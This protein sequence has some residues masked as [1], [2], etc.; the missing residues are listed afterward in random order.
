M[1]TP[2]RPRRMGG[3]L[4]RRRRVSRTT[5]STHTESHVRDRLQLPVILLAAAL[6]SSC[7]ANLPQ[8]QSPAS[9]PS[10]PPAAITRGTSDQNSGLDTAV[11]EPHA[12]FEGSG[13]F[14]DSTFRREL[15]E[16]PRM[17]WALPDTF[18]ASER[19]ASLHVWSTGLRIHQARFA[20]EVST[21]EHERI[22]KDT[23][24]ACD[25][26]GP[27]AAYSLSDSDA[28][29]DRA[30]YTSH[31]P[32][33]G[34]SAGV[35]F[36]PLTQRAILAT[37]QLIAGSEPGVRFRDTAVAVPRSGYFYTIDAVYD[38]SGAALRDA[39]VLFDSLGR[40]V[41]SNV[42]ADTGETCDG[43]G[44]I[45][46]DDGYAR[47]YNVLNA[48]VIP[49]FPYPVLFLDT[50]TVEGRALSLAT[51]DNKQRYGSYRIYEYVVTCILGDS[52]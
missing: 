44:P 31:P 6:S 34:S 5:T 26:K 13:E 12:D 42:E 1:I 3:I 2:V 14:I 24:L 49:G 9:P 39:L 45:T 41:G 23:H 17:G 43:C 19:H 30:F 29:G 11:L 22:A 47:L 46:F 16:V 18:L 21:S 27:L 28:L 48:F 25:T 4:G 40:V 10:L 50:S 33:P 52:Q 36:R 37:H 32:P 38:T 20:R 35:A 7:H 8:T 15:G 51:F